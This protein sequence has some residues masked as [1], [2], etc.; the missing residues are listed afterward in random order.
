MVMAMAGRA[1]TS[2]T[3]LQSEDRGSIL[4]YIQYVWI[5]PG[6]RLK[7]MAYS[8]WLWEKV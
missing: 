2:V 8:V 6:S 3:G 4:R 1:Q 5:K 7:P